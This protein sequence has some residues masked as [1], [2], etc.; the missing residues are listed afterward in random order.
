MTAEQRPPA[1]Q[2]AEEHVD[3][4]PRRREDFRFVPRTTVL[5]A[6]D[7]RRATR[8]M[9]HEIIERN[10]G[11]DSVVLLGL[12]R[13]GVPIATALAEALQSIEGIEVPTGAIDV[14]FYRDDTNLTN[15]AQPIVPMVTDIS[16]P[17][18][19]Q[20]VVI[21]DDVLF[22]GRTVRSALD[23]VMDFGRPNSIQLA[24]MVDRGHRELP[25][26]P[27]YVGKNLPTSRQ[28]SVRVSGDGVQIG[29]SVSMPDDA[30]SQ[31][32]ASS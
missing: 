21:C 19:E 29:E 2:D 10:H 31:G 4:T 15:R 5:D 8:R 13:G 28:E 9:A 3:L 24:V 27:D 1:A 16:F 26:R 7:M 12:E 17:V 30:S 20:D 32:D 22:T 25:I 18:S 6:D 11:L 23:A 14:S